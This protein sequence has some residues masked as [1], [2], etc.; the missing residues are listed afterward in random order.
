MIEIDDTDRAILAALINDAT[1]S[2]GALG[3]HLGLS[4]PATWRRIKRLEKAGVIAGR[5]VDLDTEKLGLGVTVFLDASRADALGL[6]EKLQMS[7]N[8][9]PIRASDASSFNTSSR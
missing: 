9:P 5:Q 2:A 8:Q 1:L 6:P 4:Q 7:A 3:R